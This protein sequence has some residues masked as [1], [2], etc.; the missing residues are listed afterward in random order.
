MWYAE[1]PY[2]G[3]TVGNAKEPALTDFQSMTQVVSHELAEAVTD[4]FRPKGVGAWYDTTTRKEI[5]DIAKD[6]GN[7][8]ALLNNYAVQTEVDKF[9]KTISPKGPTPGPAAKRLL[10]A[11][12]VGQ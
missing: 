9:G 4:A 8:I 12:K 1:I 11:S 6:N 10:P 2:P 5:G 3:G 7:Y